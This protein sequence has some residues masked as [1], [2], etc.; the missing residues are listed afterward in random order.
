[1]CLEKSGLTLSFELE[2]ISYRSHL[3][4]LEPESASIPLS[5]NRILIYLKVAL[6]IYG[7]IRREKNYKESFSGDAVWS[8]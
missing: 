4:M 2:F 7:I 8:S 5:G 6:F 1:M 3:I